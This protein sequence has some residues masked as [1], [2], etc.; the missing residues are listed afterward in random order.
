MIALS[1]QLGGHHR[2][3]AAFGEQSR[4]EREDECGELV[5]ELVDRAGAL[6]DASQFIAGDP[7]AC[8]LRAAAQT[9]AEA[10]LPTRGAQRARRELGLGPEIVQVPAHVVA[11]RCALRDQPLAVIDQQPDVELGT[12]QLRDR[13]RVGA[14]A[15]R[16]ARSRRR[17]CCRTCPPRARPWAR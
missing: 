17:R 2:A 9:R 6:A 11:Q 14:L 12:G 15:Q 4:R 8:A 5:L 16:P 1:K 13:Q 7:D 3:A 10:D